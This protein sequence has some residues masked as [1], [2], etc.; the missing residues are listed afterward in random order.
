MRLEIKADTRPVKH[1]IEAAQRLAFPQAKRLLSKIG[2]A[3]VR[4]QTTKNMR[5][6]PGL[7]RRSGNLARGMLMR[8]TGAD[9]NSLETRVGWFD[10]RLAMIA[11]VHELGTVGKGGLLPDIVPKRAP[12]LVFPL[13]AKGRA[14]GKV[15]GYVYTRRVSIPPRLGFYAAFNSSPFHSEVKRIAEAQAREWRDKAQAGRGA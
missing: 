4:F 15:E 13:R 9:I 11:R 6:R 2:Q 10:A 7:I 1:T 14:V 8:T 12:F 3:F 5:G